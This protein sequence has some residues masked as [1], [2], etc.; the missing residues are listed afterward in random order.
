MVPDKN[1]RLKTFS[2]ITLLKEDFCFAKTSLSPSL[3]IQETCENVETRACILYNFF[4]YGGTIRRR[5]LSDAFGMFCKNNCANAPASC[6]FTLFFASPLTSKLSRARVKNKTE[7]IVSDINLTNPLL[8]KMA[9]LN[10]FALQTLQSFYVLFTY[11][12]SSLNLIRHS[13][14]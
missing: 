13:V 9:E 8:P 14:I 7:D 10:R 2:R 1:R 3:N 12:I 4:T 11:S 5:I 6:L